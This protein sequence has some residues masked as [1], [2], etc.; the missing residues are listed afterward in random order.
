MAEQGGQGAEVESTGAG[1]G[2]EAVVL[3]PKRVIWTPERLAKAAATRA[4]TKRKK[5][6]REARKQAKSNPVPATDGNVAAEILRPSGTPTVA[7]RILGNGFDWE[8]APLDQITNKLADMKREYDKAATIVMRRQSTRKPTWT[9]WTQLH[10][11]IVPL[12]VQKL[13]RKTGED[14]KWASRDDGRF[15]EEN[16]LR[17]PD[18]VFCC[19]AYC[20]EMY[21]KSKPMAS[22]S[23]H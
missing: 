21:Q 14:G 7:P 9:C 8:K 20:H 19:N 6:E 1:T 18:P 3:P 17:I 12:S 16:G 22:L 11:D 10:K 4:E 5:E 2:A 15:R 13:C 23:R